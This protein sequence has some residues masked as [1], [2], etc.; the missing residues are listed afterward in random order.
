MLAKT[1]IAFESMLINKRAASQNATASYEKGPE[2]TSATQIPLRRITKNDEA[3]LNTANWGNATMGTTTTNFKLEDKVSV[4]D[5]RAV[6]LQGLCVY[7]GQVHFEEGVW[8]GIQLTGPS[9]GR[10]NCDGSYQGQKYFAHVGPKNG[11]LVPIHKVNK[12]VLAKTGDPKIDK[13][14]KQRRTERARM[15]DLQ[16]IDCLVQE[17]ALAMLKLHEE[18]KKKKKRSNSIFLA[19]DS[20]ETHITRL[21]QMRIS[22]LM[23]SRDV[24]IPPSND[25]DLEPSA[26]NLKY[27]A[28]DT[29]LQP[30]D[31]EF[32][33]GL[34][35]TQQNYCLSDPT[36]TDNPI[37]YASQ[38]FLNM[39][40][41]N[42]SDILGRNCRF[43]QGDK[44]DKYAVYRI[45]LSIKEG[46]DCHVCL[47]NY[48]KD[49]TPF[50][51]RLFMTALR[52]TKGR[53]K[54]YLGVQCEVSE[55]VA[56]RINQEER[57]KLEGRL[58]IAQHKST[59][60][61]S[62]TSLCVDDTSSFSLDNNNSSDN[63][64]AEEV[65]MKEKEK[66][67]K[68]SSSSKKKSSSSSRSKSVDPT[69]RVKSSSS[70]DVRT[71]K[72]KKKKT[73]SASK[74]KEPNNYTPHD[75]DDEF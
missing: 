28:P 36:L 9:V 33:E 53:I 22:D 31:L 64:L 32:A 62:H 58:R 52:C 59:H 63:P 20:E 60:E 56:K 23:R 70:G 13:A 10:G 8:V 65:M 43:L 4:T 27:S 69:G 2:E 67:K 18:R 74:S 3:I 42:L 5:S 15:A 14:Q 34:E 54:Y 48:R 50:Y 55:K 26:P 51:N 17:R 45:R 29:E 71:K 19:M 30:C 68:K 11:V 25:V 7:V 41:Y 6:F 24:A 47:L 38:P 44:T 37:V 40:G 61:L 66:P 12:R 35:M 21:K 72:K 46:A 75:T 57:E 39:T 49:G 16:F 73:S 1:R